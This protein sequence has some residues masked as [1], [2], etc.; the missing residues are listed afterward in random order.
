[1]GT[2]A[3]LGLGGKLRPAGVLASAVSRSQERAL[4]FCKPE[5]SR[6]THELMKPL[7]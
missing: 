7:L 1:M 5:L 4:E 2:A 3:R 6:Y